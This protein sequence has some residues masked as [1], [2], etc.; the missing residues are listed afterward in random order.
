MMNM[1]LR[2][3]ASVLGF[4][5]DVVHQLFRKDRKKYSTDDFTEEW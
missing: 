1:C 2:M 4:A 5:L 3:I